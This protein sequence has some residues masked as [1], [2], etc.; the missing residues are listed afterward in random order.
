MVLCATRV[1]AWVP[2]PI[3]ASMRRTPSR[4]AADAAASKISR[5]RARVSSADSGE[6]LSGI[7][8]TDLDLAESR[9][10]GSVPG[11]HHLL[12]LAL[13]A[14]GRAPKRPVLRARN[15]RAGIPELG[16]DAAVAGVLQHARA[17]S[18]ANLPSDLAAEL[19][20]VALVIDRP[21]LVGLH[22]DGVVGAKNFV[23][24]LP[25]R[26]EADV[27]HAN[28]RNA[29][30][31]VGAHGAVGALITDGGRGLARRH[32][33]DEQAVADDVGRLRGHAFVVESE[34]AQTGAVIEA[35]IAHDINNA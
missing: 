2:A 26:L 1:S 25:A 21:A 15:G 11:P 14:V 24:T 9:G 18:V 16:A 8:A 12:G 20:V 3:M 27:G 34:C 22:V 17:L 35:R 7:G 6:P 30:P 10:A 4:C 29:G 19:K 13:A 33:A 23:E 32:G 31:A 5:A 28:E